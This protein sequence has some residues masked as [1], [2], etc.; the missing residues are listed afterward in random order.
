MVVEEWWCKKMWDGGG[1][2]G[3]RRAEAAVAERRVQ[4]EKQEPHI[5][6]W[7]RTALPQSPATKSAHQDSHR[8]ALPSSTGFAARVLPKTTSRYQNA[9][10]AQDFFQLPKLSHMSKGPATKS[11]RAESQHHVQSIAPAT[12]FA[13]R[14]KPAR[15]SCPCCEKST[16]DHQNM[17]IPLRLP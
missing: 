6:M 4:S 16:L 2:G 1:G 9:A 10:F 7:G 11:E 17:W 12:K 15:T 14:S 3:R 8:A 13:H 5:V